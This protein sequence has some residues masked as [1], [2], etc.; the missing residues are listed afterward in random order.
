MN[1]KGLNLYPLGKQWLLEL[2][3]D[4]HGPGTG[5]EAREG[6]FGVG[7]PFLRLLIVLGFCHILLLLLEVEEGGV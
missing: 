6:C 1:L 7:A 4:G 3:G 2:S 5:N